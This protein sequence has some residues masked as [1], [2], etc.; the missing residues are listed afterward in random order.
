MDAPAQHVGDRLRAATIRNTGEVGCGRELEGL[1]HQV[2]QRALPETHIE[3]ARIGLGVGNEFGERFDRQRRRHHEHQR[4]AADRD[5][6]RK[7]LDRVVGEA[8]ADDL[9][10]D[11]R[12]RVGK[13][14]S[15]AVGLCAH[16]I[17]RD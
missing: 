3:L 17:T 15:V 8:L 4:C 2:R 1:A 11:M 12:G 10:E 9:R 16:T 7:I 6:R 14:E 13:Q 5:N